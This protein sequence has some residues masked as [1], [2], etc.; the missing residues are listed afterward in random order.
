MSKNRGVEMAIV[1]DEKSDMTT[2]REKLRE[3][4]IYATGEQCESILAIVKSRSAYKK[5]ALDD[6]EF[7][8]IFISVL[9]PR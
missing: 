9:A 1:L 3:I 2:I 5:R 4:G 6:S 8:E 7:K